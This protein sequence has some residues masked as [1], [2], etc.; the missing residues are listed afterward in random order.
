MQRL[1]HR[2]PSTGVRKGLSLENFEKSPKRGS[3]PGHLDP[4]V[5]KA[6][7]KLEKESKMRLFFIFS[8]FWLIFDSFS[9]FF[10]LFRPWGWE[11]LGTPFPGRGL[12]LFL[13]KANDVQMQRKAGPPNFVIHNCISNYRAFL[14]L[15]FA[16]P[17]VW[18]RVAFHENDGNH[19]NDKDDEDNSDSYKQGAELEITETTKMTRK[20][21]ESRVQT[22]G[23]PNHGFRNTRNFGKYF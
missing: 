13:Y 20:P 17:M 8:G 9:T 7:R 3:F 14:N 10:E 15:W 21:R 11:A 6:R 22:T 19:E 2:W 1:G 5:K 12:F 23:S 18:V 16:K 4:G